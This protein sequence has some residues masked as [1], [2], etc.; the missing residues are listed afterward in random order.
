VEIRKPADWIPMP[1]RLSG[2]LMSKIHVVEFCK[3]KVIYY[4]SVCCIVNEMMSKRPTNASLI[5]CIGA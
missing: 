5:R 3:N 1:N 2:A 4:F